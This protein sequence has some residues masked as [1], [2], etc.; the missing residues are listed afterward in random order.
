[1]LPVTKSSLLGS[2][3]TVV[4]LQGQ[5]V[6]LGVVGMHATFVETGEL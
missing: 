3:D 1:M 5:R 2:R 6:A 4:P